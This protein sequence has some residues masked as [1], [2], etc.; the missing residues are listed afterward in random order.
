[1]VSHPTGREVKTDK[2]VSDKG[3]YER[4]CENMNNIK[5]EWHVNLFF[6]CKVGK[7]RT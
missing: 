7:N 6:K 5:K 4:F 2:N 1:M 3:E